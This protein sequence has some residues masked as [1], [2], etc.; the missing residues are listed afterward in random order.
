MGLLPT[1]QSLWPA[2][3]LLAPLG[4]RA[5]NA[6][7]SL[8]DGMI[9]LLAV[10]VLLLAY[11]ALAARRRR[12][13]DQQAHLRQLQEREQR[14]RLALW[15]S[16]ELYWQFDL[17]RHALEITRVAPD[18]AND[19]IV[20]TL[21]DQDPH[22]HPDDQEAVR[23]RLIAYLRG[24]TPIFISEHR[25]RSE[26][27]QWQWM[28][29]RGRAIAREANGRVVRL[30]GTARNI[31]ALREMESERQVAAEVLRNMA[32]SVA[33]LDEEFRIVAAN[34]AFSRM[35]GYAVEEVLGQDTSLL[36]GD[37]HPPEF[38][39][40]A[41]QAIRAGR[42][43]S[44]EMW[45][46]RKDGRDFLC[47]MQCNVILDP[48]TRRRLYVLVT[49]DIT[50]RRRIEQELRY[51]ANYDPLTSLPN[52][53]QLAE[54]LAHAIVQARRSGHKL[55]LLFLDL[56]NFK[57]INDSQGHATG[58]RVL[59]AVARR[60]QDVVGPGHTV[61]R[62]SGDEFA[63][64][65]E[66]I[67]DAAEADRC[68]QRIIAA[69]ET[70]LRLDDRNEATI[71]PSIGISLFPDH[72]QVP[73]DLLKRAD[74]AMYRAKRG[75]KRGYVRYVQAMEEDSRRRAGLIAA[76]RRA[77][78]RDELSL[79]FQPVL[80]LREQRYCSVEALLRWN[81][82]DY[83]RIAPCEFI[84]LA[85]DSGL[86]VPIGEWALR[87]ACRTLADW[88]RAGLDP[89]IKLAVNVSAVQLLRGELPRT[90]ASALAQSGLPA[91]CLEL[92]LTESVLMGNA[93]QALQR[94]D[95]FAEMGVSIAVDDFGT[96]YSSLSYLRR[97]PIH[98][99]KIDKS[100]IDG[101][102][103]PDDREDAAI[104]TTIIAMAR[105]LGLQVVAEGV[106]TAA[107]LAFLERNACDLV[108]GYW[109]SRPLDAQAC[110]SLLLRAQRQPGARLDP[111]ATPA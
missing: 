34:P 41:R 109:I 78:E 36:N 96:G 11:L 59:R 106:E 76:L 73:T 97:L 19:L 16:N 22:I 27:G 37:R 42:S 12:E 98:T 40:Q 8:N 15:A 60:L 68:A 79:A 35:T 26:N 48:G 70:P 82:R 54:R 63:V 4:A 32:E 20:Q 10:L 80:S 103:S 38:Y 81:S 24:D 30:A 93:E 28:L 102:A 43:W 3:L 105:A 7:T 74:T 2:G 55:A 85:E 88:M 18:Q 75:G 91:S 67:R 57:D 100:F 77:I 46:R 9:L 49:S 83:G 21:L 53:T 84:P 86:I 45:Q 23:T 69:F 62:I 108:Q 99:L 31:D 90:A 94:L 107:Q 101:V 110:L 104:A 95:A 87:E 25:M 65:L 14:L 61:A 17:R 89:D 72:A 6:D 52:R 71:S 50:E 58:D 47:A 13:R 1:P 92:E 111:A 39:Q 64:V 5:G 66:D 44:G 29:A 33:V 56:D 51:L